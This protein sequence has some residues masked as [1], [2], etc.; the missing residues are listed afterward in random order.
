MLVAHFSNY[1][2]ILPRA[3]IKTNCEL[4]ISLQ[5]RYDV[6][7]CHSQACRLPSRSLPRCFAQ[8]RHCQTPDA[9]SLLG[10]AYLKAL[11]A[12]YSSIKSAILFAA[13]MQLI[14]RRQHLVC[15]SLSIIISTLHKHC[16][17]PQVTICTESC[18]IARLNC[19]VNA[20]N[21]NINENTISSQ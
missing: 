6:S 5:D 14:F 16:W 10:R 21:N 2:C 7:D 13:H 12:L 11:Y 18:I 4:K 19:G 3:K 8:G 17:R 1:G 15:E 9:S 20:N